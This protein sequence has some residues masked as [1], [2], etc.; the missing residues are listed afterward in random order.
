MM[1]SAPPSTHC[2]SWCLCAACYQAAV[3]RQH[4]CDAT[5]LPYFEYADKLQIM[6]SGHGLEFH[7]VLIYLAQQSTSS[8]RLQLS[9]RLIGWIVVL[10]DDD[11][12]HLSEEDKESD[13]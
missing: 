7:P 4:G 11:L 13:K 8:S 5:V 6:T 12:Q 9:Y 3:R 1:S 10:T 2:H